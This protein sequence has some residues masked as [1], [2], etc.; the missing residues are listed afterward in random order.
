MACSSQVMEDSLIKALYKGRVGC[1]EL[2]KITGQ[3]V[4]M[5]MQLHGQKER[6]TW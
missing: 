5:A 3:G 6:A 4:G 1:R 2:N